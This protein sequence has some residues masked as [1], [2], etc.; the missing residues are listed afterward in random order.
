MAH[1]SVRVSAGRAGPGIGTGT[2]LDLCIL[3]GNSD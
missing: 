1:T 2:G 3:D